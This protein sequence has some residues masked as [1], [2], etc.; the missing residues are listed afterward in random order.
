M[1]YSEYRKTRAAGETLTLPSGLEVRVKKV[2]LMDLA[3]NGEIPQTLHPL[4]DELLTTGK[5]VQIHAA[6]LVKYGE[7]VGAVVKACLLEPALADESDETHISLK[8]MEG[9]DKL[10]LFRWA[11]RGA[12]QLEKFRKEQARAVGTLQSNGHDAHAPVAGVENRG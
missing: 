2:T 3:L 9:D 10:E 7:L 11:N 5:E 6:D 8:D 4:T 12:S 1:N